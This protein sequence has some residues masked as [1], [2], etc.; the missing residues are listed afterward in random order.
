MKV[1]P[2]KEEEIQVLLNF[3]QKLIEF[4]KPFDPTLKDG[5]ISYYNILS[6]IKNKDSL[7]LVVEYNN[8]IIGSGFG[9][10]IRAKPFLKHE[11]FTSLGFF[12]VKDEYRSKGVNK[13][14]IKELIKWSKKRGV[15]EMILNVYDENTNAKAAYLK[16]GF[17]PNLLEMRMEI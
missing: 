2:A 4:E 14:I 6:K 11:Y 12:Y 17:K 10:I 1:R 8:E 13:L 15:S 5:N 3:E 16:Y 9:D 7:V